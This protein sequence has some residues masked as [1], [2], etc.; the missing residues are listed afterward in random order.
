MRTFVADDIYAYSGDSPLRKSPRNDLLS[1]FGIELSPALTLGL[2][3][4]VEGSVR[5]LGV[6]AVDKAAL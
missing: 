6:T 5:S 2:N 3:C 1:P 4:S